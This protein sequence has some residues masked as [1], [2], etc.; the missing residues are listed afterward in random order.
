MSYAIWFSGLSGA[1]KTSIAG[2]LAGK[3][4]AHNIP[5]VVLDGDEVRKTLSSDLGYTLKERDTHI[6]RIAQLCKLIVKNG[7]IVIASVISPKK[8]IREEARASIGK[9]KFIEVFIDCP[10][11]ICKERDPQGHYK[12]VQDKQITEFVHPFFVESHIFIF[13]MKVSYP[14]FLI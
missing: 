11:E 14:I 8:E 1:G 9:E 2:A 6:R 4:R 12:K 7:I 13:E 10:L 3:L 5:V